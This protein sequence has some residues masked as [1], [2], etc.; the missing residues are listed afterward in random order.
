[1]TRS[2][3]DR[4]LLLARAAT[5]RAPGTRCTHESAYQGAVMSGNLQTQMGSEWNGTETTEERLKERGR[6]I[7]RRW[8]KTTDA[9]QT[10][11]VGNIPGGNLGICLK[12]PSR[13]FE[14]LLAT[15]STAR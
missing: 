6:K 14:A 7:A 4:S 2:V 13:K 11:T 12:I 15:L 1:M 8:G 10:P 5:T 9:Q 3:V